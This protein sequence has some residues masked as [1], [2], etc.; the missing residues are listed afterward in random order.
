MSFYRLLLLITFFF[1]SQISL[2][3]SSSTRCEIFNS[4]NTLLFTI[5]VNEFGGSEFISRYDEVYTPYH[6][7]MN[8]VL[9][10]SF[11]PFYQIMEINWSNKEKTFG[12]MRRFVPTHGER[13]SFSKN[14]EV[15]FG[16]LPPKRNI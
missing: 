13:N 6:F 7:G 8:F 10:E 5:E 1:T 14:S 12:F 2:A 3:G 9:V 4:K 15:K 16:C 11:E